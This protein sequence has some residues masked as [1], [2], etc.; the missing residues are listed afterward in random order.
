MEAFLLL[1]TCSAMTIKKGGDLPG[2]VY[3]L[4]VLLISYCSYILLRSIYKSNS[5]LLDNLQ[6][7]KNKITGLID[8]HFKTIGETMPEIAAKA[9]TASSKEE[10]KEDFEEL[11][12]ESIQFI[13]KTLEIK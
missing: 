7:F 12:E 4:S 13:E 1:W 5:N 8:Y 3:T 9:Y 6:S 11:Q 2:I 10:V